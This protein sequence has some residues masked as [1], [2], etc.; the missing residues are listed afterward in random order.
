MELFTLEFRLIIL[1]ALQMRKLNIF[2][3]PFK[4]LSDTVV[5]NLNKANRQGKKNFLCSYKSEEDSFSF[6]TSNCFTTRIS[7]Y[8]MLHLTYAFQ[9]FICSYLNKSNRILFVTNLY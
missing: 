4:F 5:D 8:L 2:F 3:S 1:L 9:Q 7:I 6:K